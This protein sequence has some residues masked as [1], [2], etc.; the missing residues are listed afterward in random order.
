M[1]E[2]LGKWWHV[3]EF[4]AYQENKCFTLGLLSVNEILVTMMKRMLRI[5]KDPKRTFSWEN[6]EFFVPTFYRKGNWGWR[7]CY[8]LPRNVW[9]LKPV[10][11][12]PYNPIVKSSK[13]YQ[14]LHADPITCKLGRMEGEKE[15]YRWERACPRLPTVPPNL[16]Q[17][18]PENGK[19]VNLPFDHIHLPQPIQTRCW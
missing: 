1:T 11:T 19:A 16:H 5:F 6:F 2:Y 17:C 7:R 18:W 14:I 9:L 12:P 10:C 15:G 3:Y 8:D 4:L 13:K